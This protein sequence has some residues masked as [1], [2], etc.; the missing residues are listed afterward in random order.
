MNSAGSNDG[1]YLHSRCEY[2]LGYRNDIRG[3]LLIWQFFSDEISAYIFS[4][5]S[6][7][8]LRRISYWLSSSGRQKNL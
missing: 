1:N 3:V 4:T 6:S 7:I 8:L 5:N 2:I